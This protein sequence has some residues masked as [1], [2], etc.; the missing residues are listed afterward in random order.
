MDLTYPLH[1][2]GCCRKQEKRRCIACKVE[3][4][5]KYRMSQTLFGCI[6]KEPAI[7]IGNSLTKTK[8]VRTQNAFELN[9]VLVARLELARYCY[10]GI[11]S[12]LC[13][14]IPPYQRGTFVIIS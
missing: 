5:L 6:K 10:R 7:N 2:L 13:L 4:E 3:T 14:P 9:L 1:A 11:L 12:P 8:R